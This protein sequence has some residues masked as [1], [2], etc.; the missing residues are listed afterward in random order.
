GEV[1]ADG[2][3]RN[4]VAQDD[5]T[6]QHRLRRDAVRHVDHARVGRDARDHAVAGADEVVL[7][8]EVG[9]EGDDRQGVE[10]IT[11]RTAATRP[12]TSCVRASA[13]TVNPADDA[14]R[15]VSGPIDT[16]GAAP[17][18][19]AYARAADPDARTTTSPSGGSGRSGRVR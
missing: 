17:P 2:Q 3:V 7:Q 6:L 1:D 8:S 18:I 4:R 9:E 12:S 10:S 5:R 15:V 16:A 19:A 11:S 13:T 14:T